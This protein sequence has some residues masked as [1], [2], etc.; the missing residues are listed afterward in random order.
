MSAHTGLIAALLNVPGLTVIGYVPASLNSAQM[1]CALVSMGAGSYTWQAVGY[2]RLER[3][4]N[5][6]VIADAVAQSRLSEA[7]AALR[8]LVRQV[9]NAIMDDPTLGGEVDHVTRID[10]DGVGVQQIAGVDYLC[11][12]MR[13]ATVE[14]WE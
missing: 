6:Y 2:R 11:V 9:A 13:V 5:V 3:E 8:S 10:D 14:K 4:W 12:V 1:P 7:N